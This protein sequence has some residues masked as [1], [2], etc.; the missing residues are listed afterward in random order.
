MDRSV[1]VNDLYRLLRSE[2]STLETYRQALDKIR[3][4]HIAYWQDS[5]FHQFAQILRD[6]EQAAG[7]LRGLIRQ[8]GGSGLNDS[9][10]WG[11][12]ANTVMG[13]AKLLGDI[14]AMKALQ[15]CEESGIQDY[16][17]ILDKSA[18][19]S[20]CEKTITSIFGKAQHHVTQ[21]DRLIEAARGPSD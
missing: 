13:A 11:T 20:E 18:L 10:A 5:R 17:W 21:L 4:E 14:A 12:R 9:G 7:Q 8:M 15:E 3:E 16:R 6:H 19:P 1:A 2:L